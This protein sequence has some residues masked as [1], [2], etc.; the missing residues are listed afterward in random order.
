MKTRQGENRSQIPAETGNLEGRWGAISP[1]AFLEE[2]MALLEGRPNAEAPQATVQNALNLGCPVIETDRLLLRPPHLDDVD[3][4]A[5]L[6]NN[7]AVARML[8]SVP[9]PYFA[10]DARE[11]VERVL[12][13]HGGSVYAI[14]KAGNG[15]FM[16]ISGLHD[17]RAR[18][19]LPF[20]GY[21][22]GEP[23]WGH[24]FAT[25]AARAMVDLFFKVTANDELQVSCRIEN[26]A[27]RRVIAKCGGVY[28]KSS[29]TFNRAL[30]EMQKVD[31]FRVTRASWVATAPQ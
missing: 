7:Y 16:G 29:N 1:F 2:E 10:A 3:D 21:W 13:G 8:A 26:V 11:F 12:C 24:G 9:H 30:G 17:D 18:F 28:W 5:R 14:T 27:S 22:L 25:E 20:L 6:A 15:E 4:I 31:H 19:E 23:Y